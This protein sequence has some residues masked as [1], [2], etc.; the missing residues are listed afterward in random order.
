M[1]FMALPGDVEAPKPTETPKPAEGAP[2]LDVELVKRANLAGAATQGIDQATIDHAF[3]NIQKL[4]PR[5]VP[6]TNEQLKGLQNRIGKT[7]EKT[8]NNLTQSEL[9]QLMNQ[10]G[11][12]LNSLAKMNTEQLKAITQYMESGKV[13]KEFENDAD[14]QEAV[15]N[16]NQP[17]IKNFMKESGIFEDFANANPVEVTKKEAETMKQADDMLKSA[18][19]G[20]DSARTEQDKEYIRETTMGKLQMMG[21]DVTNE[22]G[23][24]NGTEKPQIL[25]TTDKWEPLMNKVIGLM[26]VVYAMIN[27]FNTAKEKAKGGAKGPEVAKEPKYSIES[28]KNDASKDELNLSI[29]FEN[30]PSDK[31]L[32]TVKGIASGAEIKDGKIVANTVTEADRVKIDAAMKKLCEELKAKPAPAAT[33]SATAPVAP[34]APAAAPTPTAPNAPASAPVAAG[35]SDRQETAQ[36]QLT[37]DE[38]LAALDEFKQNGLKSFKEFFGKD[39]KPH[40]DNEW[41]VP[42]DSTFTRTRY[43]R[44]SSN[45]GWEVAASYGDWHNPANPKMQMDSGGKIAETN[46]LWDALAKINGEKT[47]KGL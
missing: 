23:L 45:R 2:K 21:I 18:K 43:M 35:A 31:A 38:R 24:L 16:L 47:D 13:P 11:S 14:V 46:K 8:F 1:C 40:G 22:E 17:L 20:I 3:A 4:G 44:F 39:P 42:Q 33:P 25:R 9:D 37:Q 15:K 30:I 28:A 19:K 6:M 7:I 10:I 32:A 5:K 29:T 36:K 41:E 12:M 26:R 34:S 27:K